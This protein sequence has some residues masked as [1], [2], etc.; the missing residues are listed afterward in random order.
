MEADICIGRFST[1]NLSEL[2]NMVNKT[3][4]YEK[5][6][7]NYG[8]KILL[9]AHREGA[10][11]KYQGCSETIRTGNY[12]ESISFTT[13]YGAS[14]TV[15]GDSATN[16]YVI[17]NI[18]AGNNI[19]NYRG[20]GSSKKWNDWNINHEHFRDTLI[21]VLNETTND[22]YFCVACSLGHIQNPTCFMETFMRSN[23]GAAG[24]IAASK[25]T[26]TL[27]NHSFNQ[28]LFSKLFNENIYNIGY[29][30]ISAHIANLG[31]LTG[32]E[33]DKAEYNA[34]SYLCGCDPSLEILTGNTKN[35]NNYTLTLG[36]Q[37]L[38]IT[39]GNTN[40]YKVNVVNEDGT[41][42]FVVNSPSYS[43]TIPMPTENFYLILNKHNYV[44]RII[45][46]NVTD[47]YIQNKCFDNI[48]MEYYYIRDATI[49]VGYDVTSSVPYG[50]V[51]IENGS[52][53]T[54]DKSNGVIFKNGTECKL[55]GILEIK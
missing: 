37:N 29:L 34:F 32:S 12:N 33:Y 14:S 49:N 47:N 38:T 51:T 25:E 3:I 39:N 52:K 50:N 46:V 17:S 28:Y 13:A 18:N 4:F 53:L 24:M 6:P 31:S 8:E 44:P 36:G 7:R 27:A 30:N 5:N 23:H 2:A 48:D 45:Y 15:N 20:H 16:N 1:N 35:F 55:G 54:I 40:E 11:G 9:V 19:I 41:L 10:P 26:Y 22:I 43:C 21:N 42:S